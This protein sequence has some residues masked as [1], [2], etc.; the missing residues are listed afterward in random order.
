MIKKFILFLLIYNTGFLSFSNVSDELKADEDVKHYEDYI[1][2]AQ[3]SMESN[4]ELAFDYA[5]NAYELAVLLN[6][7]A[8]IAESNMLIGDVFCQNHSYPTAIKYYEDAIRAL[9]DLN[10]HS[11]INELYIKMASLYLDSNFDKQWSIEAM[12]N[13]VASAI[14]T[15]NTE[16]IINTY[17]TFG[18]VYTMHGNDTM[19]SKYYKKV[20]GY[21]IDAVTI[22]PIAK[23]MAGKSSL[24]LKKGDY[25]R[26]MEL[27]D[28]SLYLSIRDFYDPL[29][30]KNYGYKAAI[31]D[32]L[33]DS[34]M[35]E[36][37]YCE[38]IDLAYSISNY[39]DCG[40]YMLALGLFYKRNKDYESS[41]KVLNMLSDSTRVFKMYELCYQSY[42]HLSKCLALQGK[43]E[44]AYDMLNYY[45]VYYDSAVIEKQEKKM[46]ELRLGYLLSLNVEELKAKEMELENI[47]H[48]R[49]MLIITIVCILFLFAMIMFVSFIYINNKML[50]QKSKENALT[51]QLKLDQMENDMIELQLKNNK[52]SLVNF[53]FH[54]K[55]YIDYVLPLK[56]DVKE[57]LDMPQDK[58]YDKIKN[59]YINMQNHYYLFHDMDNLL[60]QIDEVYKDFLGKLEQRYP[61]I[62]KGEKR[63]CAM[64][65]IDMSSKEIAVITN[66]TVRSV[67]TSRYRLRK[68]FD[69]KRDDDIVDF[70]KS[71]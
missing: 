44:Q 24:Y 15:N 9:N 31:Y 40:R 33:N 60:D 29:I 68:K 45:D 48:K 71:I 62:T 58:L 4:N 61:D 1:K 46:E 12:T 66:T 63:L 67:E 41:I 69:L 35:A 5:H 50:K 34:K 14:N 7:K 42:Y 11:T 13:A 39:E 47:K 10:D 55:S 28:S 2:L 23:A 3:S 18:Y 49:Y 64:L 19:A 53:A 65:Y 59:I 70:L 22:R 27:I 57:A 51:Q 6:D 54:L 52:E 30:A 26:A 21:P 43:Y 32:S 56:E 36:K 25:D 17:F 37:Y 16:N 8:K 38:A 20:L